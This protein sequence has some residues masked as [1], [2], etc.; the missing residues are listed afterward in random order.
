MKHVF[1]NRSPEYLSWWLDGMRSGGEILW[2]KGILL[3]DKEQVI[4]CTTANS[5][6]ILK[7]GEM[8]TDAFWQGNTI[9]SDSYR[10]KGLSKLIYS[11]M[12]QYNN[13]VSIGITDIAWKIQSHLAGNFHPLKPVHVY[14]GL[15]L[16][17]FVFRRKTTPDSVIIDKTYRLDRVKSVEGIPFPINGRW[18][19]DRYE[20]VRDQEFVRSRFF[21]IYRASQYSVFKIVK[22]SADIGY[23]VVRPIRYRG[24][25]LLSVV[26]F[27]I[28]GG[29]YKLI[30]KAAK[31]LSGCFHFYAFIMLTSIVFPRISF[32]PLVVRMKKELHCASSIEDLAR[33]G[34]LVTSA[35]SDLDFVYYT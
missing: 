14:V 6:R 4:G 22:K 24:I 35:D 10:G 30:L 5:C 16:S 32:T 18:T 27:R 17:P 25:H 1:P 23:V 2:K 15:S 34:M 8:I 19:D 3:F 21:D 13:W 26:D 31:K 20:L 12:N 33:A 29:D 28:E 11:E 9:I 7:E